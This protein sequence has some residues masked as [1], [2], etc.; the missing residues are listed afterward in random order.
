MSRYIYISLTVIW[1]K[2]SNK[3]CLSK[4][5]FKINT[6]FDSYYSPLIQIYL[7]LK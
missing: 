3:D 7:A 1:I 5:K 6:S 4:A 2:E